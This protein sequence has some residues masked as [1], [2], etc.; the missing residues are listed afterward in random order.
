[1]ID[2]GSKDEALSTMWSTSGSRYIE[3]LLTDHSVLRV[4]YLL[5]VPKNFPKSEWSPEIVVLVVPTIYV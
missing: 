2:Y 4:S 1:M 5:D 3:A